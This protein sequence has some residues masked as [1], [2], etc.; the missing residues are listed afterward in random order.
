MVTTAA[1]LTDS[2]D[3]SPSG[4]DG[5]GTADVLQLLALID[6]RQVTVEEDGGA[7]RRTAL[8]SDRTVTVTREMNGDTDLVIT[9]GDRANVVMLDQLDGPDQQRLTHAARRAGLL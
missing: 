9:D 6:A 2:Q 4:G 5:I 8:T 3:L 7:Q 1:D